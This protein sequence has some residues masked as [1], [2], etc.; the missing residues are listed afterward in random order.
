ML[1]L[2]VTALYLPDASIYAQ[3][4]ACV[5]KCLLLVLLPVL[6]DAGVQ[7]GGWLGRVW[8]LDYGVT[9]IDRY[10]TLGSPHAPP[11][12]GVEGVVDQTRGILNYC[13]DACP[14]AH[15]QEVRPTVLGRQAIGRQQAGN[16][17][18]TVPS[19]WIQVL[20]KQTQN[21]A[22]SPHGVM[23]FLFSCCLGQFSSLNGPAGFC[24][25][26]AVGQTNSH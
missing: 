26:R 23:R 3:A 13:Q 24:S 6:C 11:P 15:H 2:H 14:G 1:C 22:A 7:A 9:G 12:P 18:R 5:C 16:T 20:L 21:T 8:M 10:I 4:T 19:A 25:G 17:Q